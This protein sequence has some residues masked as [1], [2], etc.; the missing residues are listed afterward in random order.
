MCKLT[1]ENG[2]WWIG[3]G[4][5]RR[6]DEED[7]ASKEEAEQEVEAQKDFDWEA[8]IDEAA[9]QEES[10]SDDQFFYAQVVITCPGSSRFD[11]GLV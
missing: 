9:E 5:N 2:V 3:T 10:G 11:S 8:V 4:E 7:D 6:R 1:K